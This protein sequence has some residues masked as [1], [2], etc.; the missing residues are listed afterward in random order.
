MARGLNKLMIIGNLGRAP[1]LRYTAGG[2]AVASLS[3]AVNRL[4]RDANGDWTEQADWFRVVFWDK[5][6]ESLAEHATTG[7]KLYIEGELRQRSYT[8]KD[9]VER[10]VVEIV[11]RE[12]I[13]L[14]EGRGVTPASASP[15]DVDEAGD[16]PPPF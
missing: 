14:A 6:A 3:V 13:F 8:D 2:K 5:A 11:G 4:A 9:N 7:T 16:E 1:E 12:F 15:A 10:K